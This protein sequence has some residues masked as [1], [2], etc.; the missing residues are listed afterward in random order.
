MPGLATKLPDWVPTLDP[1]EMGIRTEEE[2]YHRLIALWA[3]VGTAKTDE[4]YFAEYIEQNG[5]TDWL[6]PKEKEYLFSESRTEHQAI[7]F[8]WQSECFHFLAW[9]GGLFDNLE[10]PKCNSELGDWF[11]LFP[12]DLEDVGRLRPALKLRDKNDLLMWSDKLMDAHWVT[13]VAGR[14][15]H[16]IPE[17]LD[18]EVVQEW[19]YAINW[20]V[21][22]LEDP[23]DW[24]DVTTD[25]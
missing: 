21:Y 24:D 8:S 19:H 13:R 1:A 2:L 14:S 12:D 11:D 15:N 3:I 17:G 18:G 4:T 25:T 7:H 20:M 10:L 22:F 16:R 23:Q 6:S 9:C 5:M